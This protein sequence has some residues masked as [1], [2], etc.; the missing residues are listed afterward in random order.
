MLLVEEFLTLHTKRTPEC[1]L[2]VDLSSVN[3]FGQYAS[4]YLCSDLV[5]SCHLC[6]KARFRAPDTTPTWPSESEPWNRIH[7]DWAYHK[8]LGNVLVIADAFSGWLEAFVCSSRTT[9]A[10]IDRLRSLF[11]RFG[12][13]HLLVSDNAP[14]FSCSELLLWLRAIGCR[15]LHSPEYRPQSNG[16]AERAVRTIKD[17]LKCYNPAKCSAQAYLH[18]LLFVHRNSANRDTKTPSDLM[19]GRTVRCPILS[20]FQLMEKV[21]YRP[22]KSEPPLLARFLY[23]QGANTSLVVHPHTGRAVTAHDAQISSSPMQDVQPRVSSGI[24][25]EAVME[26]S[27]S[28]GESED[29]TPGSA[30]PRILPSRRRAPPERFGD[31]VFH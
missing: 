6:R 8:S 5:R 2:L 13:P 17:A 12:V 26:P 14:E 29:S 18:R 15:L 21:L 24:V 3:F 1:I 31:P 11:A 16:L 22:R 30:A 27:P 9:S 20:S 28:D 10:V 19:L 7:I 4:L 23:R 25:D